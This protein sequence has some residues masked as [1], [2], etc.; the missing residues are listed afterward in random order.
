MLKSK[1]LPAVLTVMALIGNPTVAAFGAA[2]AK[3]SANQRGAKAA[4]QMS[5]KGAANTNAQW[6]AD[7]EHGWIRADERHRLSQKANPPKPVKNNEPQKGKP[8]AKKS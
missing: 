1:H 6:S 7:P 8:K 3:G 4:E 2:A 5:T